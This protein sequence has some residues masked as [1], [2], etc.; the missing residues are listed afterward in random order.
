MKQTKWKQEKWWQRYGRSTP[1]ITDKIMIQEK[2]S[3]H[4]CKRR[5]ARWTWCEEVQKC[6]HLSC[7]MESKLHNHSH[8]WDSGRQDLAYKAASCIQVAY[9]TEPCVWKQGS[10]TKDI[11]KRIREILLLKYLVS[12]TQSLWEWKSQQSHIS[13]FYLT[14]QCIARKAATKGKVKK[15]IPEYLWYNVLT[16]ICPHTL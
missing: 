3:S 13:D 15:V 2:L 9:N 8:Q 7:F 6:A 16:D 14:P 11:N 4:C 1:K 5:R 12:E 10:L